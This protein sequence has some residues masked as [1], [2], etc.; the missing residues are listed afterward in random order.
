M[1]YELFVALRYLFAKRKQTL[2]SV[3]SLISILGVAT[4]VMAL[5]IALAL[6]TGFKE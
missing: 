4:G 1:R 5:V 3:I 6:T 2:L